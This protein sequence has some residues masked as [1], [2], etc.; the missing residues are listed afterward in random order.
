MIQK[1]QSQILSTLSRVTRPGMD[2][3]LKFLNA[4]DFFTAPA[5]TKFHAAYP[6]GLAEHS[7][8]VY[9]LFDE[10]LKKFGLSVPEESVIICGLLHDVCK[11]GVYH[12][13]KKN[14]KEDGKWTEKEV[15][16]FADELPFG[17][18]DKSVYILQQYIKL[19]ELEAMNI[20][21]HMGLSEPRETW[22]TFDAAR[23]KYPSIMALFVADLEASF[24]FEV[25]KEKN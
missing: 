7:W 4:S 12:K 24:L 13:E 2:E 22:K 10:K 19:T 23:E 21:W 6:G 20:R 8:N 5:S 25:R 16:A 11:I 3:L 15:W 14:V 17:H 9:Q 18:G 1:I